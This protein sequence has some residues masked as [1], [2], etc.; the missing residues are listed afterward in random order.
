MDD[1]GGARAP[2]ETGGPEQC[3]GAGAGAREEPRAEGGECGGEESP[4]ERAPGALALA[5][6]AGAD[7]A[8]SGRENAGAPAGANGD[9]VREPAGED[10]R[11][12]A[13]AD[14]PRATVGDGSG[15]AEPSNRVENA[16]GDDRLEKE[17]K[18]SATENGKEIVLKEEVSKKLVLKAEIDAE[19]DTRREVETKSLGPR[20]S[21]ETQYD[22]GDES[23]TEEEQYAFRKEVET[24]YKGRSL[25]FKAPKFYKEELNLLK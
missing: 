11:I 19:I 20:F 17:S 4:R 9:G 16:A 2:E 8:D 23:G 3:E 12:D 14:E 1:D 7:Q 5:G 24:F 13:G 18:D 15:D 6:P 21:W 10:A 25:E 22:D